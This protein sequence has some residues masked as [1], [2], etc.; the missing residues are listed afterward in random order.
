MNDTSNKPA[1]FTF[2]E[3]VINFPKYKHY[4]D[5]HLSLEFAVMEYVTNALQYADQFKP[6]RS[7]QYDSEIDRFKEYAHGELFESFSAMSDTDDDGGTERDDIFYETEDWKE[8]EETLNVL[9]KISA[10]LD[11]FILSP[12]FAHLSNDPE[13]KEGW[14]SEIKNLSGDSITIQFCK[15]GW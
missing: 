11:E 13:Y 15:Q 10:P 8:Y 1:V 4:S 14:V 3:V 6:D 2:A 12:Y 5:I 9:K 7:L